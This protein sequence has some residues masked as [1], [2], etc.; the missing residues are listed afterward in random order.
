MKKN[1]LWALSAT[2][3]TVPLLAVFLI[4]GCSKNDPE[5]PS[6][7]DLV[8][9]WTTQ[10]I[11]ETGEDLVLVRMILKDDSTMTVDCSFS[12]SEEYEEGSSDV[13]M[14]WK[15]EGDSIYFAYVDIDEDGQPDAQDSLEWEKYTYKLSGSTLELSDELG[16]NVREYKKQQ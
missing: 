15:K 8:G 3:I 2:L 1:S 5:Q 13:E 12:D 10:L 16:I 11:G 6:A 4:V 9:T 14:Y 7:K